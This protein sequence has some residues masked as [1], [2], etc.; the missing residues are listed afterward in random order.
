MPR[1]KLQRVEDIDFLPSDDIKHNR[2]KHVVPPLRFIK[3]NEHGVLEVLRTEI[4]THYLGGMYMKD[5]GKL[6]EINL[7]KSE[8]DRHVQFCKKQ[9]D[10]WVTKNGLALHGDTANRLEDIIAELDEDL[11]EIRGLC[12][13]AKEDGD[14]RGYT[15]LKNT[16]V[17]VRKEKAK[18]QNKTYSKTIWCFYGPPLTQPLSQI[19]PNIYHFFIIVFHYSK[20]SHT[21]DIYLKILTSNSYP[22]YT[23]T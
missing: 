17:A 5:I 7:S 16:E 1:E 15:Q 12:K 19:A 10:E 20:L 3:G 21:E 18:K 6:P 2:R 4:W 14:V 11:I 9:Y 23:V 22:F 13:V 8:V